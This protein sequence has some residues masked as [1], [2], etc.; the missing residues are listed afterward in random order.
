MSETQENF[1]IVTDDYIEFTGFP[2]LP[3]NGVIS[4][5]RNGDFL[6]IYP[7]RHEG[8]FYSSYIIAQKA[9]EKKSNPLDYGKL[10]AMLTLYAERTKYEFIEYNGVYT[11]A[12][13]YQQNT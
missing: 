11:I 1:I 6:T 10:A 5:F 9:I 13:D 8:D 3:E 7:N 2:L 12:E 4:V